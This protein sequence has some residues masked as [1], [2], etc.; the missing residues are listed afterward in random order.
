[1]SWCM[2]DYTATWQ[3]QGRLLSDR[4]LTPPIP[5]NFHW[6]GHQ[7]TAV[8]PL[9]QWAPLLWVNCALRTQRHSYHHRHQSSMLQPQ[10]APHASSSLLRWPYEQCRDLK[11]QNLPEFQC[12]ALSSQALLL[13]TYMYL[14]PV[15]VTSPGG[16]LPKTYHLIT[17]TCM[18]HNGYALSH[19]TIYKIIKLIQ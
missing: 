18:K 4:G 7:D 9:F 2:T 16:Y 19:V 6:R 14:F 10:S 5:T 17:S 15:L 11:N 12:H 1:M 3:L 8:H 13:P